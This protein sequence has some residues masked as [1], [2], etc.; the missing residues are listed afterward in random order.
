MCI[1]DGE[2]TFSQVFA[3]RF[4][5]GSHHSLDD[6]DEGSLSKYL[7]YYGLCSIFRNVY[8][9]SFFHHLRIG[10]LEILMFSI[11]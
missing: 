11:V 2:L 8:I 4:C 7:Y 3:Y 6:E 5:I 9:L 10:V 1:F